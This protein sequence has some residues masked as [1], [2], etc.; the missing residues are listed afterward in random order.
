MGDSIKA[1]HKERGMLSKLM[2]RRLSEEERKIIYQKWGIELSSK[3]RRLQLANRLWSNTKDM[4]HI[5][6][7]A[8]IVARLVRFVEQGQALKEMCGLSF[9]PPSTRRRLLGWTFSI[10]T[11]L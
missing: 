2:Q 5:M 7:S 9:T 11:L 3:R 6:E 1:L 8:A 4:N 10:S